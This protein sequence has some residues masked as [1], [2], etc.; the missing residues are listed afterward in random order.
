MNTLK[1]VSEII[2]FRTSRRTYQTEPLS[3]EIRENLEH[4]INAVSKGPL[5]TP[6]TFSLINVAEVSYQKLKLGTY[7]FI[8]GARYFIAGQIKPS[9]IA[10]LDY[11]FI[12][13][14]LIL[15]ITEMGL[16]T[17][18]LGGT[19]SRSEFAKTIDLQAG[20][21]IPAITPV[22]FATKTRGL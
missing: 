19:F 2:A 16:G 11:G 15:D 7:G 10:F 14:K 3:E 21:V 1:P 9:P 18:W 22:G 5:G 17:C 6:I 20:N 13:E 8:Q 12:L 4:L